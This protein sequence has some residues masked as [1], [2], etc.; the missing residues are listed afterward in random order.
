M[1]EE[2]SK[3][4]EETERNKTVAMATSRNRLLRKAE[5]EFKD[6]DFVCLTCD[7]AFIYI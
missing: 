6:S 4:S 7:D 3:K 5:A 1:I 2:K